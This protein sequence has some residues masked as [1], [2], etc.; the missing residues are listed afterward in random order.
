MTA[1]LTTEAPVITLVGAPNSGK[2]TLF[3]LLSGKN[4]KTVN[5]PGSTVEYNITKFQSKYGID[6]E[7]LDSPGLISLFPFSPDEKVTVDSLYNHPHFGSPDLIINTVD[8]S[9]LSRHLLLTKQLLESGFK[10]IVVLTMKD[11]LDRK[12]LSINAEILKEKIDCDVVSLNGRTGEGLNK[13]IDLI[14]KN[15][16]ELKNTPYI[17]EPR[18]LSAKLNKENLVNSFKEIEEI[19]NQVSGN[20]K[21]H[22]ADINAAN[23]ALKILNQPLKKSDSSA[24][25]KI[26]MKIDR[27]LQ[28]ASLKKTLSVLMLEI[29][30]LSNSLIPEYGK[31]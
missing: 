29:S 23:Q 17:S 16:K 9:Q 11:I 20:H 5:Y 15:I 30:L 4:Y 7:L 24:P 25:D 22:S 10:V 1:L 3:N 13:L 19:V 2:T 14:Q 8:S 27:L 31:S 6:S 12:E 28:I 26:T 21:N 18:R